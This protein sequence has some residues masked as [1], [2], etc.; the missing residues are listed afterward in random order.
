MGAMHHSDNKA[1]RHYAVAIRKGYVLESTT[2]KEIY[3]GFPLLAH[4]LDHRSAYLNATGQSSGGRC[5]F[6]E[7]SGD[8]SGVE[9]TSDEVRVVHDPTQERDVGAGS[10]DHHLVETPS[11]AA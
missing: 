2:V 1:N 7:H 8:E 11:G 4:T 10:L 6:G 3:E 9:V 5:A